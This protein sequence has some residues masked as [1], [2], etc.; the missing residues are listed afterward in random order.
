[1]HMK[2]PRLNPKPILIDN[3]C[4]EA[5]KRIQEQERNKSAIG[6]APSLQE[7][8]R[9]LIRKALTINGAQ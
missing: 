7:I 1:M 2:I 4:I 5:M 6:V 3:D 8:A 9:G